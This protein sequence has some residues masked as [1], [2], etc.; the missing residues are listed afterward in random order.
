M[1]EDRPEWRTGKL[2]Y[3]EIPAVDVARSAEFYQQAF[4]WQLRRRGDGSTSFDDTVGQVSGTFVPGGPPAAEPGFLIYI[5]VADAQATARPAS[6]P[7]SPIPKAIPSASP[8]T[9][10]PAETVTRATDSAPGGRGPGMPA[11][12][13]AVT[14]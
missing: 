1:V 12:R 14:W 5:M 4:G 2:C 10:C 11:S 9:R 7:R 8:A 13:S 6:W 3:V